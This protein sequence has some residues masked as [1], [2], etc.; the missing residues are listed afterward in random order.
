MEDPEPREI[1]KGEGYQKTFLNI[2]FRAPMGRFQ[3]ESKL[4]LPLFS[5][6]T[7]VPFSCVC[8]YRPFIILLQSPAKDVV[9]TMK[10]LQE[11][12]QLIEWD[13]SET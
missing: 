2:M 13:G 4:E 3:L 12:T 6:F 9:R 10:A 5:G 8:S 1:W 11:Q 7:V